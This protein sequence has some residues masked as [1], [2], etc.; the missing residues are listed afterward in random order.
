MDAVS[1]WLSADPQFRV[2]G[3]VDRGDQAVATVTRETPDIV[4]VDTTVPGLHGFRV[5]RDIKNLPT[6]P[7]VFLT[8]FHDSETARRE[9]QAAGADGLIAKSDFAAGLG[10]VLQTVETR[11]ST[12]T[13]AGRTTPKSSLAEAE[14]GRIAGRGSPRVTRSGGGPKL[15]SEGGIK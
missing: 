6:P 11:R 12:R 5:A 9:A 10:Q 15:K 7:L 1:G 14:T 2:I 8:T 3:T 4:F 13:A